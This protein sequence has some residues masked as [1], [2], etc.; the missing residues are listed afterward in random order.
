M[1]SLF[2]ISKETLLIEDRLKELKNG[3]F[4]SYQQIENDTGVKMDNKGKSYMR[5]ALHRLKKEYAAV[6]GQGIEIASIDNANTI[7]IGRVVKIDNA[8]KRGERTHKILNSEFYDQMTPDEQK[9]QTLIGAAFGVLRAVAS[10]GKKVLN[11]S[12]NAKEISN[13]N[14]PVVDVERFK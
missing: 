6:R 14:S 8:V 3:E 4:I 1:K 11:S 13:H 12:M 5:S 9:Q 10:N 2:Q 7:M